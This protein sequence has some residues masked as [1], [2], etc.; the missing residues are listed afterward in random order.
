MD[1][2]TAVLTPDGKAE[3]YVYRADGALLEAN[4]E[5]VHVKMERDALGRNRVRMGSSGGTMCAGVSPSQCPVRS[6][7]RLVA[8]SSAAAFAPWPRAKL[9]SAAV[10]MFPAE[11]VAIAATEMAFPIVHFAIA[12][13]EIS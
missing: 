12:P 1:R 2:V 10:I 8:P 6:F 7:F 11:N 13:A 5:L 4:N 3:R 9:L